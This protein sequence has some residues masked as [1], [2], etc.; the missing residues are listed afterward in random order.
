MRVM[1]KKTT[2]AAVETDGP[3]EIKIRFDPAGVFL[4]SGLRRSGP[5][6]TAGG[7]TPAGFRVSEMHAEFLCCL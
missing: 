6:F 3:V 5:G 2:A 7:R 4:L 1:K